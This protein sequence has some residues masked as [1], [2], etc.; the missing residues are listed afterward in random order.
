MKTLQN[1]ILQLALFAILIAGAAVLYAAGSGKQLPVTSQ[2]TVHT[3][4]DDGSYQTGNDVPSTRFSDNGDG[5][6]TDNMTGL[7]WLK[8]PDSTTRNWPAA[9]TYCEGLDYASHTDWRLP[10]VSELETLT[11]YSQRAP[12][13]WLNGQGFTNV[14]L[15][16]YWSSTTYAP[17]TADAWDVNMNNGGV[18]NPSKANNNCVWP[19]RSG[20]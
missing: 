18:H 3:A 1:R 7:M 5:T 8:S 12:A 10:T 20:Q 6:I 14:R 16:Y 9:I 4:N 2:T 15:D 17:S 19:V 11:N 13:T